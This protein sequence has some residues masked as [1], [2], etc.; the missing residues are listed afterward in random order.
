MKHI[1]LYIAIILLPIVGMSQAPA[2]DGGYYFT[3]PEVINLYKGITRLQE[4]DSLQ[5]ALILELSAQVVIL[6]QTV[7]VN[8]EI[9]YSQKQI[10]KAT[11]AKVDACESSKKGLEQAYKKKVKHSFINGIITGGMI[12]SAG[13][14]ATLLY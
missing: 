2:K 14:L 6:E 10:T 7:E 11:Q 8:K 4:R 13:I 12:L 3:K 5:N 1:I 9:L